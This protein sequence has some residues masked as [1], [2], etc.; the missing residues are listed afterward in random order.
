MNV[1]YPHPYD[2][3]NKAV[4]IREW[5]EIRQTKC[6][7]NTPHNVERRYLGRFMEYTFID[8]KGRKKHVEEYC[9]QVTWL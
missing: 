8:K 5:E 1:H 2:Q 6:P 9:M 7:I 3:K 4:I